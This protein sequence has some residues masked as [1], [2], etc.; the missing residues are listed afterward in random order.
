ML[1]TVTL[2]VLTVMATGCVAAIKE[3][4]VRAGLEQIWVDKNLDSIDKHYDPA[5][6]SSVRQFV[7]ESQAMWP[8]AELTIKDVVV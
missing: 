1:R 3:A 5:I 8:D 7:V 2:A 6:A 4:K